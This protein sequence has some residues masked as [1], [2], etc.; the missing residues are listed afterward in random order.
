MNRNDTLPQYARDAGYGDTRLLSNAEMDAVWPLSFYMT[1]PKNLIKA[2]L[3]KC[4]PLI[5]AKTL[6]EVIDW[7]EANFEPTVPMSLDYKKWHKKRKEWLPSEK[8][9][10]S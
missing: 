9:K 6:K 7:L 4:E 1:R 8:E 10:M 2:Q 3:A 5:R